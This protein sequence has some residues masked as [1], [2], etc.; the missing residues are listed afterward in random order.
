MVVKGTPD[1]Y[2][3]HPTAADIELLV[4]VSDTTLRN[5][6]GRKLR[7]YAR[8]RVPEYWVIDVKKSMIHQMWAPVGKDY[9]EKR[10][11]AFGGHVAAA[12]VGGLTI[13]TESL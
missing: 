2:D 11:I 4:E 10:E 7:I 13:D 5:D 12:T 9:A 8:E 3:D 6:L 1:D